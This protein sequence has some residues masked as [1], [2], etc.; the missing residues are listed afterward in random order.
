MTTRDKYL[1]S[2][3]D[4]INKRSFAASG[5]TQQEYNTHSVETERGIAP[6][7]DPAKIP[8]A[9]R[10]IH[11]AN[12]AERDFTATVDAHFNEGN[13]GHI[14][15]RSAKA[16]AGA[17]FDALHTGTPRPS[18][19]LWHELH[20]PS[21]NTPPAPRP[22]ASGLSAELHAQKLAHLHTGFQEIDQRAFEHSGMSRAD[23]NGWQATRDSMHNGGVKLPATA[24]D[25]EKL[26]FAAGTDPAIAAQAEKARLSAR[27]AKQNFHDTVNAHFD[28]ASPEHI[29]HGSA[30][31]SAFNHFEDLQAGTA[32][33][34]KPWNDL[35]THSY[36]GHTIDVG[37]REAQLRTMATKTHGFDQKTFNALLEDDARHAI[38]EKDT[39]KLVAH[40][41]ASVASHAA[42]THPIT[43]TPAPVAPAP[44]AAAAE[45]SWVQRV[46]G[47][48]SQGIA[49]GA[50][51]MT[52]T[53]VGFA[54]IAG[55]GAGALLSLHALSTMAQAK[56]TGQD[57]GVTD[58]AEL[59]AGVGLAAGSMLL[60]R[61]R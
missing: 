11:A 3:I 45:R 58:Y 7:L 36:A 43:G 9:D 30:R 52:K 48:T 18:E 40:H 15:H 32:S 13:T 8:Q 10:A 2:G 55:T 59:I 38:L 53:G 23:Y 4:E 25:I 29:S 1:R 46:T 28:Q 41:E 42:G 16:A 5:L 6:T 12:A 44:A 31:S 47:G 54:K 49:D 39:A 56:K 51:V 34:A 22:A 21:A 33:H 27:L 60:H 17:H 50:E 20:T 19:T 57:V 24:T 26:G 37:A 35:H 61:G 14:S